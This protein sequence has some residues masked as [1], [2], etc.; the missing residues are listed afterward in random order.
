MMAAN[1]FMRMKKTV[2]N[3]IEPRNNNEQQNVR[4]ERLNEAYEHRFAR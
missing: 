1:V 3:Q 2:K 4:R